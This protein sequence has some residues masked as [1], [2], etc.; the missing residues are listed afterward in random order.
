MRN[1][2]HCDFVIVLSHLGSDYADETISDVD[3]ASQSR[4]IDLI[5]GGH[6][7]KIVNKKVIN[8]CGDSVLLVQSG[9][10]GSFMNK[11]TLQKK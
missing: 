11:T 8:L 1:K 4:N 5:I 9:K 6:T 10:M 2:E 3:V 7:H